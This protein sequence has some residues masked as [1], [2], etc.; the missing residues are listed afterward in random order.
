MGENG[1]T[2]GRDAA[3]PLLSLL[4]GCL[5]CC[6]RMAWGWEVHEASCSGNCGVGRTAPI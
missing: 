3:R 6:S 4:C 5:A 2:T 1:P